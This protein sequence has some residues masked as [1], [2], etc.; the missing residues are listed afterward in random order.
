MWAT[1]TVLQVFNSE[2]RV[3]FYSEKVKKA[4]IIAYNAHKNQTDKGGYPYI[5]HTIHIAEQMETE[6]ETI[7]ALLHDVVEDTDI[8][9]EYLKKEG[10]SD[11]VLDCLKILTRTPREDYMEYIKKIKKAGG[12]ALKIKKADMAHNMIKERI[13]EKLPTDKS[14]MEKYRAAFDILNG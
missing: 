9:F 2:V 13:S 8:S 3:L 7:A 4:A 6:E 10:F 5:M 14:R 1:P 12:I 11:N